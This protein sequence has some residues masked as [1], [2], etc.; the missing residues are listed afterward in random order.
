MPPTLPPDWPGMGGNP[1]PWQPALRQ[2][3]FPWPRSRLWFRFRAAFAWR[4][5][6]D[7]GVWSYMENT[8]TRER[9]VLY[10]GSGQEPIDRERLYSKRSY[11]CEPPRTGT[12]DLR[13]DR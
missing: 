3:R 1:R 4:E 5:V 2:Q 12:V 13:T 8:L 6:H 10:L 11:V 7:S 9:R